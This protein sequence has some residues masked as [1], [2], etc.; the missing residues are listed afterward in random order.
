MEEVRLKKMKLQFK[1]LMNDYLHRH[2]TASVS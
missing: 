1:D 2:S